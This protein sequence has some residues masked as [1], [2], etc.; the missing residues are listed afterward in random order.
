MKQ[1]YNKKVF[2]YDNDFY[3]KMIKAVIFDIGGVI[4]DADTLMED[5]IRV[6]RPEDK[7]RFWQELNEKFNSLSMGKGTLLELWRLL[8]KDNGRDIPDD[9]LKDLLVKDYDKKMKIDTHV[10]EMIKTLKKDYKLGI[11][12]NTIPEH[13]KE[14]DKTG[15][16]G[17][18]DVVIYSCDV[19]MAKGDKEIFLHTLKELGLRP[20][21]CVFTDDTKKFVDIASSLGIHAVQFRD[22]E[23]FKKDLRGFG[24]VI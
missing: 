9:V 13:A 12:S 6:F 18:F 17:L 24:V 23:Q 3:E 10:I 20:D 1:G 11:I 22:A 14:F 19:R 21:E 7:D 16:P 15:V 8:A 2:E 5:V 4:L